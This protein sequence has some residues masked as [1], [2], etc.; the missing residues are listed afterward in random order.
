[1]S[2]R[3][4]SPQ[5]AKTPMH[6]SSCFVGCCQEEPDHQNPIAL[7]AVFSFSSRR[8][9]CPVSV[10]LFAPQIGDCEQRVTIFRLPSPGLLLLPVQ[11]S[12]AAYVMLT[13]V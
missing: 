9:N 2:Y 4:V 8:L 13:T 12:I 5:L 1:M 3:Q 6:R 7:F 10:S 11:S